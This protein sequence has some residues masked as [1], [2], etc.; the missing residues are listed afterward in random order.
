MSAKSNTKRAGMSAGRSSTPPLDSLPETPG[1]PPSDVE[2]T[3]STG[4][5]RRP[6]TRFQYLAKYIVAGA[7][8]SKTD[9]A[10]VKIWK[11]ASEEQV[12]WL[13]F[14]DEYARTV[15]TLCGDRSG[16]GGIKVSS[17]GAICSRTDGQAYN[18]AP[19]SPD[20][21]AKQHVSTST[22]GG[23]HQE[24]DGEEDNYADVS[25]RTAGLFRA[26]CYGRNLSTVL[27]DRDR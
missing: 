2:S 21:T 10:K 27:I 24:V 1:A 14:R 7:S 20:G 26:D 3:T 19:E 6:P 23:I 11:A 13:A 9:K 4:D 25:Q 22:N 16:S 17:D 5:W 8:L 12:R 15:E 18:E